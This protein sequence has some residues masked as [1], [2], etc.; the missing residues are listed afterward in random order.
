METGHSI[1]QWGQSISTIT[2]GCFYWRVLSSISWDQAPALFHWRPHPCLATSSAVFLP[3]PLFPESIPWINNMTWKSYFIEVVFLHRT[4]PTALSV[5]I[6]S[7]ISYVVT[8]VSPHLLILP[9]HQGPVLICLRSAQ[10]RETEASWKQQ[11]STHSAEA[12]EFLPA[13]FQDSFR[14]RIGQRVYVKHISECY[15]FEMS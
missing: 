5:F 11:R 2:D 1:G 10:T 12:A 4:C 3:S 7:V 6:T 15:T 9:R 14:N 13:V 8:A